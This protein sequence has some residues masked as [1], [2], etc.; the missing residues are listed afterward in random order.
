MRKFN[1]LFCFLLAISVNVMAPKIYYGDTAS[2]ESPIDYEDVPQV[3]FKNAIGILEYGSKEY[4]YIQT[5]LKKNNATW[6]LGSKIYSDDT[7]PIMRILISG[8]DMPFTD[9]QFPVMN[10]KGNYLEIV[11]DCENDKRAWINRKEIPGGVD[12][13]SFSDDKF[14]SG[15]CVN[16]FFGGQKKRRFYDTPS[17]NAKYKNYPGENLAHDMTIEDFNIV[18]KKGNWIKISG[19]CYEK[20][21]VPLGWIPIKDKN[22]NLTIWLTLSNAGL[23]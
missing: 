2:E 8:V 1:I 7:I 10:E 18:K 23:E 19:N 11:Y 16:I 17:F 3:I 21:S 12:I 9:S 20:P 14:E 15:T 6:V 4:D 13:F 22:G 5:Y